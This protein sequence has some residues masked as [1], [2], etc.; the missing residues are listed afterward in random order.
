M[1]TYIPS[2]L[3]LPPIPPHH[4]TIQVIIGPQAEL[5]YYTAGSHYLSNLY[6][7]VCI[8]QT[9]SPNSSYSVLPTLCPHVCPL[10]QISIPALGLGSSVLFF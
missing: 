5:L 10:H 7:V 9:S 2:L 4:P 3:D 1:Y 8:C 6:M